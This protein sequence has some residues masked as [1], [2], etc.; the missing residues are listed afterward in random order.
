MSAV[1]VAPE[2]W[3]LEAGSSNLKITGNT[4]LNCGR[5]AISVEATAGNGRPAPAGA[6]KDILI[7]DNIIVGG[8]L[9]NVHVVG[10]DCLRIENNTFQ[11]PNPAPPG[12]GDSAGPDS[13]SVDGCTNTT[14]RGS[15]L[16]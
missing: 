10:T 7:A 2:Y 12:S 4:I 13:L 15:T 6:H 14:I 8:P 9:P 3:W 11:S 1:L 5:T 16:R